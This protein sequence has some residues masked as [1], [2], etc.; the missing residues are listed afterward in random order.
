[1]TNFT[2]PK[3]QQ[4]VD[5]LWIQDFPDRPL[6]AQSL[7]IMRDGRIIHEETGD[8]RFDKAVAWAKANQPFDESKMFPF[9][10]KRMLT[11]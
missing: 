2:R 8:D 7:V 11:D 5:E 9:A 3:T 1:M 4:Q 10:S 6:G